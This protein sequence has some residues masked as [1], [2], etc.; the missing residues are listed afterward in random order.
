M[1]QT[2]ESRVPP[3]GYE[4]YFWVYCFECG[5]PMWGTGKNNAAPQSMEFN[6]PHCGITNVFINSNQPVESR[7]ALIR[8]HRPAKGSGSTAT[9][10]K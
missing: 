2:Q 7:S 1:P 5:E 10:T 9:R 4:G 6:C 3:K 8:K